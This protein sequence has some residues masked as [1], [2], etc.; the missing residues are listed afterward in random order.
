MKKKL[1]SDTGSNPPACSPSSLTPETDAMASMRRATSEWIALS[2]RLER[3]RNAVA[4]EAGRSLAEIM[5]E[6]DE[7]HDAIRAYR[8]AKGRYHTQKACERLLA[9]LPENA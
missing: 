5:E 1:E 4:K 3:E 2:G 8:D 7:L 9:L 6:R